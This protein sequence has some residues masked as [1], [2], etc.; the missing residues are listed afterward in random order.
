MSGAFGLYGIAGAALL[1]GLGGWM[2]FFQD[3]AVAMGR[4]RHERELA[5]R[6]A[7]GSDAWF[8]ELRDLHA[9]APG[10]L[11]AWQHRLG[12][13]LMILFGIACLALAI[14]GGGRP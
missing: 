13:A 12:G 14:A 4:R 3:H 7:R 2:L 11:P 10:R 8:E 1:A 5:D 6:L 9:Y